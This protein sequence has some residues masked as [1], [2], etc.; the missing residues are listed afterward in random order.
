MRS[1]GFNVSGFFI[2]MR[3]VLIE[4]EWIQKKKKRNQKNRK[5]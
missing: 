2:F 4:K 1:G 5:K 3:V